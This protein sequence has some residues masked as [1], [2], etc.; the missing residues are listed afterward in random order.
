MECPLDSCMG[1]CTQQGLMLG[2]VLLLPSQCIPNKMLAVFVCSRS[3]PLF[4]CFC[5]RE[6]TIIKVRMREEKVQGQ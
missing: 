3:H 5:W 4:R 1:L 6:E 2:L